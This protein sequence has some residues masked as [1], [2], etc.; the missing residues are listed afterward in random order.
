M[1]VH[2]HPQVEKKSFKEYFL[3]FIMIF[4]AVT[5]GFFA[6]SI[7]ENIT[8]T[9]HVKE[10]SRQLVMDLQ[11]DTASLQALTIKETGQVKTANSLYILL[12]Q[13]LA[14]ADL[15]SIQ[16]LVLSL[17]DIGLFHPSS[18]ATLSI[19][20]DIGFKQFTSSRIASHIA[21]YETALNYLKSNENLDMGYLKQ[22]LET[23]ITAHFT[24]ANLNSI[25][26]KQGILNDEMRNLTQQDLTQLAVYVL[27]IKA[28]DAQIIDNYSKVK[29]NAVG[30]MDYVKREFDLD[31]G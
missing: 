12:Q 16:E 2:H 28:F 11:S 25:V 21:S 3:E 17:D 13:P 31:N 18:G 5:M 10:L 4:L 15:K 26:N 30:F 9:Q 1:E 27:L 22:Y 24:P 29:K 19:K 14:G 8:S 20:N 6:E 23:F 7:R